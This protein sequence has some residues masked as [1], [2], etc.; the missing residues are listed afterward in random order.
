MESLLREIHFR[1][2]SYV[3]F[4]KFPTVRRPQVRFY[5]SDP[6]QPQSSARQQQ[7]P[8]GASTLWLYMAVSVFS[9]LWAR[10]GSTALF[11]EMRRLENKVINT[12]GQAE[13]ALTEA[14]PLGGVTWFICGKWWTLL[15][16]G[17][18][19]C[20]HFSS[21]DT[22]L[23]TPSQVQLHFISCAKGGMTWKV[24]SGVLLVFKYTERCYNNKQAMRGPATTL[25]QQR[26]YRNQE[27]FKEEISPVQ[28]SQKQNFRLVPGSI[29]PQG[30]TSKANRPRK[31][32]IHCSPKVT[33]SSAAVMP[34]DLVCLSQLL[35]LYKVTT[36]VEII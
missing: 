31:Y 27:S 15:P 28:L 21:L 11:T 2:K 29:T 13:R 24:H 14:L 3:F 7:P 30:L 4:K 16:R 1:L 25:P 6:H 34:T 17:H 33:L 18:L 32:P 5:G 36:L 23:G 8:P 19:I 10:L 26:R 12:W 35:D 22:W 20:T 9:C